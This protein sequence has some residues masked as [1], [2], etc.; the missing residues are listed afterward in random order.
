MLG[1]PELEL[2]IGAADRVVIT[3]RERAFTV[4]ATSATG[5]RR[6]A[7]LI[8]ELE[9]SIPDRRA[10]VRALRGLLARTIERWPA[11]YDDY[12]HDGLDRLRRTEP[13]ARLLIG[14]AVDLT[15]TDLT[16]TDLTATDLTA[17]EVGALRVVNAAALEIPGMD[18][19]VW[20]AA[21]GRFLAPPRVIVEGAPAPTQLQ[22]P[23]LGGCDLGACDPFDLLSLTDIGCDLGCDPGCL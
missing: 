20:S 18:P 9:V 12:P 16:A 11:L 4:L 21:H 2:T 5:A 15:A 7:A 13:S 1:G 22:D 10:L 3:S 14:Y 6:C 19:V 23:L 8:D 17:P